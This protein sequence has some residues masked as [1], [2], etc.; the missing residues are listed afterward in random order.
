MEK[1]IEN[2]L[3]NRKKQSQSRMELVLFFKIVYEPVYR[4][5]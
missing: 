2:M 5:K 4:I 1:K 3:F